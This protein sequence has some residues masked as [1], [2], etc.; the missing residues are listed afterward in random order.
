MEIPRLGGAGWDPVSVLPA[1]QRVWWGQ[2]GARQGPA[3][4]EEPGAPRGRGSGP[5]KPGCGRKWIGAPEGGV[6]AEAEKG[7]AR[8]ESR[9]EGPWEAG[10]WEG[11]GEAEGGGPGLTSPAPG[12]AQEWRLTGGPACNGP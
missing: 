2:A 12:S 5:Q 6:R 10:G 1:A 3:R 11:V 8:G 7:G 4:R 9:R